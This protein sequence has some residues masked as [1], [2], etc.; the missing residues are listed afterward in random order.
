M[1]DRTRET[2]RPNAIERQ[3]AAND[4]RKRARSLEAIVVGA[5]NGLNEADRVAYLHLQRV[6][7]AL[8][9]EVRSLDAAATE[10]EMGR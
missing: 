8:K 7:G 6:I 4:Y 3:R 5:E 10:K 9:G 2:T 1:T